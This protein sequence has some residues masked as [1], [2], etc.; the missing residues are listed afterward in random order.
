MGQTETL[1]NTGKT[2]VLDNGRDE[3]FKEQGNVD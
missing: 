1:R 2:G 3:P